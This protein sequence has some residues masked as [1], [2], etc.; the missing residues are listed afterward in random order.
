MAEGLQVV[1]RTFR[2][3]K[4]GQKRRKGA[5]REGFLLVYREV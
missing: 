1:G 2:D 5:E 4:K 3:L